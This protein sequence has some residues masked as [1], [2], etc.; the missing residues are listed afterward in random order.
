MLIAQLSDCH[1]SAPGE[2]FTELYKTPDRL[3]AAVDHVNGS[4]NKPD[5]V[6]LTGDLVNAGRP[7]EY[8]ILRGIV[9]DLEMPYYLLSG[10]HDD[11]DS[12]RAAFPDHAYLPKDG[13]LCYV[14][15]GWPLKLICLDTNIPGK[16]QGNLGEAQLHWLERELAAEKTRKVVIFMHH[17]P[18]NTGLVTMDEMGLLDMAD[19]AGVIG[20]HDHI[21]RV[22][23]G[24]LHRA[25]QKRI[26]GT[27]AQCCPSTSHQVMLLLG[28]NNELGTTFEPPEYLLHYWTEEDG[29]VTHSDYVKD[30]KVAWTLKGGVM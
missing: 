3:K 8:E 17:P 12:L 9:S 24:H 6:I 10:N 19:F 27:L 30:Y 1:V 28:D 14:I 4:V 23:C 7:E 13:N 29:L 2:E 26:G 18:F 21:E 25:I 22:L 15:D 11:N 5:L 16:P 20:R